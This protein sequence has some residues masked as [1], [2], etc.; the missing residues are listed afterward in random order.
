MFVSIVT[1]SPSRCLHTSC[2]FCPCVCLNEYRMYL[3]FVCRP[4]AGGLQGG[5]TGYV[6]PLGCQYE[7]VAE[8]FPSGEVCVRECCCLSEFSPGCLA[9]HKQVLTF[10]SSRPTVSRILPIE[11]REVMQCV[12]VFRCP[13]V[14]GCQDSLMYLP[15]LHSLHF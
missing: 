14:K 1:E 3:S 11:A 8:S 7:Y 6:N 9:L 15:A 12:H 10:L 5:L 4:T 13:S 2:R